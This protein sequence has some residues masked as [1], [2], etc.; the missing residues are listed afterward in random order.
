MLNEHPCTVNLVNNANE[1]IKAFSCHPRSQGSAFG[2]AAA[3]MKK[4]YSESIKSLISNEEWHF[5]AS[6]ASAKQLEDFRIEDM[7]VTM[8][9]L[10]PDLWLVLDILLMGTR[11]SLPEPLSTDHDHIMSV[12]EDSEPEP[13][14]TVRE[15]T[16]DPSETIGNV[17]KNLARREALCT[18][19]KVVMI[20]IMMQSRNPKCNALESVFGIFLHSTSTPQKVIN[21]LSH[22]GI[23]IS[24]S[25]I[26]AAIHSLSLETYENLRAMGQTCLVGYAYDNFDI[27]FKTAVPTIEKIGDTLTHLTSGTLIMLEHGVT[28]EDLKCSDELWAK[29]TIN[30]TQT[31][32]QLERTCRDLLNLHP[33]PAVPP[34]G[35]TRRQRYQSW[36][37]R[38]DLYTH[39]PAYFQQFL[40]RLGL[41]EEID[42]IPVVKMRYAPARSM[43][44]NESTHAGNIT[45]ITNLLGQGGVGDP[46]ALTEK[47]K[48]TQWL[49]KTVSV[50]QY[51]VLFFGDLATFERV[52]GVLQRRS[53]EGTPWR[54]FQFVIFVMGLFHLK[55][56]AADAIWRIFLEPKKAREDA[57]SLMAFVA[58][59]RPRE[60]AK[61]GSA[62]GF[63]R[64]HEVIA[65]EGIV[66]RLDAWVTE[67]QRQFGVNKCST[68]EEFAATSPSEEAI[69][70]LSDRLAESYV[71][72]GQEATDIFA[73]RT[74]APVAQRD[75]Q[76]ENILLMHKYF[77]LYEELSF[78]MNQGDIGRVETLFPPWITIFRGTGKHKYASHMS[79]FLS[80]VH[81][82]YPPKLR[83]AHTFGGSGSNYTQKRVIEESTLI[84]IYHDCHDNIERNFCLT[85][86]TSLHGKPDMSKSLEVARLY[87]NM[88]KPNTHQSGRKTLHSI[89]DVMDLGKHL[90]FNSGGMVD[91]LDERADQAVEEEDLAAGLYDW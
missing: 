2:W 39:G 82:V 60:T 10:A 21:A 85:S 71:A 49:R 66:L 36:K 30:P 17:N 78:A 16:N 65:H 14:G 86:L 47:E 88:H 67:V 91:D 1:I 90:V 64:M 53:I 68:L 40:P 25:A 80:D 12:P 76:R 83:H 77:F 75:Q 50:L 15:S 52:M 31:S 44:V 42:Q 37:F 89:P 73:L 29:S 34:S 22:M 19:K 57:T 23:S 38:A 61:I 74:Q 7:A 9:E 59:H 33:E 11:M 13:E 27:D 62:P 56:A 3:T 81:F 63:R 28:Q 24:V 69:K 26:H 45:A 35:L 41:P 4:K 18:I 32:I 5:N 72:G 87:T 58:L 54:R 70:D 20:S 46:Q 8:K 84:K 48:G 55:M 43:D 79:K 6:H 51:V